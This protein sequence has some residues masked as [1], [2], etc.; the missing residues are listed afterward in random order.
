DPR[1]SV[2]FIPGDRRHA[3]IYRSIRVHGNGAPPVY[4]VAS[5]FL[6]ISSQQF[7]GDRR[8][9]GD[10]TG[11]GSPF[12][13]FAAGEAVEM[14]RLAVPVTGCSPLFFDSFYPFF[15]APNGGAAPGRHSAS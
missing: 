12:A 13:P 14:D 7:R 8:P 6:R 4:P 3:P 11:G 1:Y 10:H 2:F 5:R 15:I 9:A